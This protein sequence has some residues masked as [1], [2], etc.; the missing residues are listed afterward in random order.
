VANSAKRE[1]QLAR[2]HYERQ[3]VR[4]QET[5][6]RRRRVQQGVAVL[7]AALLVV[8]G[9]VAL[10]LST[11]SDDDDGVATKDR[12][13]PTS[14]ATDT[15]SASASPSASPTDGSGCTYSASPEG[16]AKD[17]GVPEYDPEQAESYREPFTA[18]LVT[19]RGEIT[20]EM[21]AADAP[22]TTNSFR[23]LSE[24]GYYDDTSCHRVTTNTIFVLQCG[25]PTGSG[26]GG[27]GY[28]FGVE[29]AP[30]DGVYPAG[31][32][33]MARTSDPG[34]N[35]SQFF[36]VYE[37]TTLPD[38]N[39]YTVFGTVTEGLDVVRGI[40]EAGVEGGGDDGRP[41]QPITIESVQIEASG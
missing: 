21:A 32:V 6:D 11:G 3:Q 41:A 40:A 17:V 33:A 22:C 5:A 36:V 2:A 38:P 27:P 16:A 31:T 25:D 35:G 12:P 4:R 19:D 29:N 28:Q 18:T 30:A 24:Q 8:G 9:V 20:V 39:G 26:S 7:V 14:P 15:G 10:G 1:R 13:T 23:H 34:S 37:E